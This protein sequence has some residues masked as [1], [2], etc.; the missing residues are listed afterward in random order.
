MLDDRRVFPRL[1]NDAIFIPHGRGTLFRNDANAFILD[2]EGS[3]EL[4]RGL[5]PRLTGTSSLDDICNA[6]RVDL[7]PTI[8]R[9]V[10]LLIDYGILRNDIDHRGGLPAEVRTRF[11][12][13]VALL[14]HLADAPEE[15]FDWFRQSRVLLMGSGVAFRACAAALRRNGLE[16][17]LT[18][19][20]DDDGEER[21]SMVL[22]VT[23]SL[24]FSTLTRACHRAL[25]D[26]G[27]ILLACVLD[28]Q[29]WLGPLMRA[30]ACGVC[31]FRR[32][33]VGLWKAG[34]LHRLPAPES[35]T[36]DTGA[37]N[38]A[39]ATRLGGD[40]AFEA[41]KALAGG[42]RPDL[43]GGVILQTATGPDTVRATFTPYTLHWC[44]GACRR[45]QPAARDGALHPC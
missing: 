14:D 21:L 31:A 5:A 8:A 24:C 38:E 23:D 13:Q 7:R 4:M 28:D 26:R 20:D 9:L 37:A 36:R 27:L 19:D 18:T 2:E 41:F 34:A 45:Y 17:L 43:A 10:H 35:Q 30:P 32:V 25:R 6:H 1:A 11:A 12:A 40:A 29:T 39:L 3:Y 15:R 44:W 16:R 33:S 42:V 22:Y